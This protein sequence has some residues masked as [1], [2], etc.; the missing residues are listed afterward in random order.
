MFEKII[1]CF[2]AFCMFMFVVACIENPYTIA[3]F[4][5]IIFVMAIVTIGKDLYDRRQS[6]IYR[7]TDWKKIEM[8]MIN[9]VSDRKREKRYDRGYYLKD[10]K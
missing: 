10:G 6:Y 8:D 2:M 7:N 1:H 3:I 4:L 5:F 9:G